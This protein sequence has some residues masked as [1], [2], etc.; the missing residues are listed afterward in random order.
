MVVVDDEHTRDT[1]RPKPVLQVPRPK[2]KPKQKPESLDNPLAV[3][4]QDE[5]ERERVKRLATEQD[6]QEANEE[7]DRL[8][9][10]GGTTS[11]PP[12]MRDW[13][14]LVFRFL[15]VLALAGAGW[16]GL[17]PNATKPEVTERIKMNEN[18]Q[19]QDHETVMR[20]VEYNRLKHE[21]DECRQKQIADAMEQ[22]GYRV[23]W[24]S[25]SVIWISERLQSE[26]P[27]FRSN[28]DCPRPPMRPP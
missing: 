2:P 10:R 26:P 1:I 13:E 20:L 14:K 23:D 18:E 3:R 12:S 24:A 4:A 28:R 8:K 22:L 9:K 16:A 21:A 7:I 19:Q 15:T 17:K 11:A 5:A 25:G 27:R 6:L